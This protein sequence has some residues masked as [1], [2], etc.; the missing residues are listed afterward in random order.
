MMGQTLSYDE[1]TEVQIVRNQ[2]TPL[3]P[4]DPQDLSIG[5]GRGIVLRDCGDIVSELSEMAGQPEVGALIEQKLHAVAGEG[6]R[7]GAFVSTAFLA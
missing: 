3:A 7:L 5:K 6:R 2:N 1:V 4:S